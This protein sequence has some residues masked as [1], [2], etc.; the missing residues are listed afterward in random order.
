M[1]SYEYY[2]RK[3]DQSFEVRDEHQRARIEKQAG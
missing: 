3:C 2:C 1:P